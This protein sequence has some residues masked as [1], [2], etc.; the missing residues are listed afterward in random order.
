MG[1]AVCVIADGTPASIASNV[2]KPPGEAAAPYYL[3]LSYR[4]FA[5][6]ELPVAALPYGA[7]ATPL[8]YSIRLAAGAATSIAWLGTGPPQQVQITIPPLNALCLS[9][10]AVA[11]LHNAP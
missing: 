3:E 8:P 9:R 5:E 10:I 6:A 4:S 2:A 11:T 7:G 1:D